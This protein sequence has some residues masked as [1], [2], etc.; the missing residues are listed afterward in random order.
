MH[1]SGALRF[2]SPEQGTRYR[3]GI[4]EE[5]VNRSLVVIALLSVCHLLVWFQAI[6]VPFMFSLFFMYLMDPL[7]SLLVKTPRGCWIKFSTR[8]DSHGRH[9]LSPLFG[10]GKADVA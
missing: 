2:V 10:V 3:G 9:F 1:G 8:R 5:L 7:V 6:I 4:S